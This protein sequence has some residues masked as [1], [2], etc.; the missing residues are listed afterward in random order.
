[1]ADITIAGQRYGSVPVSCRQYGWSWTIE[2]MQQEPGFRAVFGTGKAVTAE[3]AQFRNLGGFSG[4]FGQGAVGDGQASYDD[5]DFIMS[6][7]AVGGMSNSERQ[8]M[9]RSFSIRAHC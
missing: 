1:M 7:T 4:T 8:W 9:P 6:G 5:N 2:S 3:M